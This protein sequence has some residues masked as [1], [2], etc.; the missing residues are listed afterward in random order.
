MP[1]LRNSR[2]SALPSPRVAPVMTTFSGAGGERQTRRMPKRLRRAN[3][4]PSVAPTTQGNQQGWIHTSARQYMGLS[5]CTRLHVTTDWQGSHRPTYIQETAVFRDPIAPI[6][7]FMPVVRGKLGQPIS[8][9]TGIDQRVWLFYPQVSQ[10][11]GVADDTKVVN[12]NITWHA[13]SDSLVCKPHANLKQIAT[14]PSFGAHPGCQAITHH[15]VNYRRT[16][17]RCQGTS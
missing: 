1:H 15:M 5:N 7:T 13:E 6:H 9:Y 3:V 14:L 16:A 10:A 11:L 8:I 2:A 17:L 4:H 12:Y